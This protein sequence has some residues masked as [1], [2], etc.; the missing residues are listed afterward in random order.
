ME[1]VL[2][3]AAPVLVGQA[4]SKNH[5]VAKLND[6]G[7]CSRAV[8]STSGRRRIGGEGAVRGC[9]CLPIAERSPRT[10][11]ILIIPKQV[12]KRCNFEIANPNYLSGLVLDFRD[13]FVWL[14]THGIGLSGVQPP[15]A[16]ETI[17]SLTASSISKHDCKYRTFSLSTPESPIPSQTN[18]WGGKYQ[19]RQIIGVAI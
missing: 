7:R 6:L 15:T 8:S 18:N 3:C 2:P 16:N 11:T 4:T 14:G 19:A 5:T 10:R 1:Y 17:R 9:G 12:L 13:L